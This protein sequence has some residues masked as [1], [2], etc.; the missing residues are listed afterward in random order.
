MVGNVTYG[1]GFAQAGFTYD[2]NISPF[3]QGF[4]LAVQAVIARTPVA[5]AGTSFVNIT[6]TGTAT[7]NSLQVTTATIATENVSTSTITQLVVGTGTFSQL[8]A[9]GT[10]TFN[11]IYVTGTS[12]IAGNLTASGTATFGSIKGF[13]A[14]AGGLVDATPDTGSFTATLTGCTTSPTASCHWSKQGNQ[15]TVF[16]NNVTGTSN[17]TAMTLT[18]LPAEIQPTATFDYAVPTEC[19]E[20]GGALLLDTCYAQF[21][22]G[23]GTITFYLNN[24]ST[25]WGNTLIKGIA[26]PI[27]FT[28]LLN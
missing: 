11:S 9:S 19:L 28:Y 6:V 8:T 12:S 4:S 20:S 5:L 25:G 26:E 24:S 7:I 22:G 14:T 18:G 16:I 13:G 10:A 17:T 27:L 23:S 2:A 3:N 1:T 21:T 15:V